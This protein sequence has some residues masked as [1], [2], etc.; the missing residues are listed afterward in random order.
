MGRRPLPTE[1]KLL[2]LLES[3]AFIQILILGGLPIAA[4]EAHI[5]PRTIQRRLK[6]EGTFVRDLSR[7]CRRMRLRALL[8][9]GVPARDIATEL[10]FATVQSLNRFT[11]AEFG[12]PVETLRR[13]LLALEPESPLRASM[14][15]RLRRPA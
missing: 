4:K 1:A 7:S 9:A 3:P 2:E 11:R 15:E 6:G 10:G 8:L 12:Q 5:S 13:H 14:P